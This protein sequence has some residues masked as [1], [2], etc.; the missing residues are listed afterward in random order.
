MLLVN[1]PHIKIVGDKKIEVSQ[2]EA[3]KVKS[4]LLELEPPEFVQVQGQPIR[5][6]KII[7]VFDD[8]LLPTVFR[9]DEFRWSDEELTEWE[10]EVFKYC[11]TFKCYLIKQGA[12]VVNEWYPGGVVRSPNL[13]HM[14]IKKWSALNELRYRREKKTGFV[15]AKR[16]IAQIR[17]KL[18]KLRKNTS[19]RK[20]IGIPEEDPKPEPYQ[21]IQEPQ[22]GEIDVSRI[23][24]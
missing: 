2:E 9:K 3:E 21:S 14:F 4:L 24:F 15:G 5:T 17:A 23:P 16:Q 19:M 1:M 6:G 10:K 22:D 13:Y 8:E 11:D 7:G 18:A 20:A 12:W